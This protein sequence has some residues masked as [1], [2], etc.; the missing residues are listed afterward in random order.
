MPNQ[1][2]LDDAITAALDGGSTPQ[3]LMDLVR[4]QQAARLHKAERD[5]LGKG[6]LRVPADAQP[7]LKQV[8]LDDTG[9]ADVAGVYSEARDALLAGNWDGFVVSLLMLYKACRKAWPHLEAR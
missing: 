9:S 4:R 6:L 2:K 7:L 3:E 5:K 8:L 1:V